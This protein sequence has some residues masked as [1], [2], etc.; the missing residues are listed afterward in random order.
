MPSGCALP[1]DNSIAE[2]GTLAAADGQLLH[3]RLFKPRISIPPSAIRPSSRSTA[4]PACS[5]CST[6]GPAAFTQILTRAGYVVF[7]LDNRGSAFRGTA[8]QAPIHGRLGEV[9]SPT[10]CE[11]ARWLAAQPFVDPHASASG[12]GATAAT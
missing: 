2:F 4:A 9:E 5:G 6:T 8:F 12:A 10:R 3:Y 7:Q 1:A 11:G